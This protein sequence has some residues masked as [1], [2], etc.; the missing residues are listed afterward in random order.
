[1]KKLAVVVGGVLGILI[2]AA[3]IIPL[4]V[5][6][7]KYRPQIVQAAE[8]NIN[9]K[10]ALGKLSL[11]LWGQIRVEIAG[12]DLQDL[13]GKS[14]VKVDRAY[15]HV[16]FSSIFSGSPLLTLKMEKPE[17]QVI[18]SKAGKL[19][20]LALMK[21]APAATTQ[22]EKQPK[23]TPPQKTTADPETRKSGTPGEGPAVAP[24]AANST[25]EPT[26]GV[27]S[28][29]LPEI[30][31]RARLGIEF[32]NAHIVYRD[33][34]SGLKNELNDLNVVVRDLSLSRPTELEIWSDIKT[35][36]G[37]TL[38]VAGPLRVEAR[39]KPEVAGGKLQKIEGNFKIDLDRLAI[40]MPGTFS[41]SA[42]VPMHVAASFAGTDAEARIESFIA[43]FH[44][45]EIKMTGSVKDLPNA[46]TDFKVK[47]NDIELSS[48][49]ELLPS[50]SSYALGGKVTLDAGLS[51]PLSA[52]K[53]FANLQAHAVTAKA[54]KVKGMV[55]VNSKI[56]VV[57][58][59]IK[60]LSFDFKAPGAELHG[61]GN[62]VSFSKP[63]FKMSI[64]S[65][66]MNLDEMLDLSTQVSARPSSWISEA[67]AQGKAVDISESYDD[68]LEPLRDSAI[69]KA[70]TVD[71]SFA[72]DFLQSYGA[73]LTSLKAR[74]TLK[75]LI[76]KLEASFKLW[77]G[78]SSTVVTMDLN[79]ARPTYQF[80]TDFAGL[81]MKE[82]V[83]SQAAAFK[84]TAYGLMGFKMQGS[85]SSFD[86]DRATQNLAAKGHFRIDQAVFASIDVG[87][88]VQEGING[89]LAKVG[90]QVPGLKGKQVQ[91]LQNGQS[92]YQFMAADFTMADGKFV[93]P[94]FQAKAEPNLGVDLTGS[95]E[96]GLKDYALKAK[97][98]VVDTYNMTKARDLT[99]EID[100]TRVEHILARGNEPVQFPVTVGC[101][102]KSPCYSYGEVPEH[103]GKI[104][105]ENVGIA[106]RARL[107]SEAKK[108]A[109]EALRNAVPN[110]PPAVKDA[111]KKFGF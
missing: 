52:L 29:S 58:D 21:E 4:V 67:H 94:N 26:Q 83:A 6:V 73:R 7:D 22:A 14:M 34:T 72:A 46:V 13:Q 12:V 75:Q 82:A 98:N 96:L 9:G 80:T 100:G 87:K 81:D 61:S 20:V 108:K 76:S 36:L 110:A 35:V 104:A 65:S 47:S 17:V 15:F 62:L 31:V 111:L 50:L 78:A 25:A 11:S 84:N 59:Q 49:T 109:G 77:K 102:A 23:A 97:W 37:K 56:E 10:L 106:A 90:D 55:V 105:L 91:G 19:N 16:P 42:K 40:E 18:K 28:V 60:N 92:K 32:R 99:V 2:L 69:A 38:K 24:T 3:V 45:A 88:M 85:G 101:F 79:K 30:A 43:R 27:T 95:T 44:N 93:M 70:A 71:L 54:P 107:E 53:Y 103:F 89:A 39:L 68:M 5:D 64:Q 33:D 48:W 74:W 8:Q 66:G 57:T 63:N 51:G 86:P 1:M 41:K